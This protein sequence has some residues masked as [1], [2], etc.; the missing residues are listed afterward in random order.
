MQGKQWNCLTLQVLVN[1]HRVLYLK[2]RKLCRPMSQLKYSHFAQFKT[3]MIQGS[4]LDNLPTDVGCQTVWVLHLLLIPINCY[5]CHLIPSL[6]PFGLEPWNKKQSFTFKLRTFLV[7]DPLF[8]YFNVCIMA[9]V[10]INAHWLHLLLSTWWK[11][12]LIKNI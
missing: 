12:Y 3:K 5:H 1:N 2:L 8:V 9:F 7:N 6:I 11:H 4:F 10:V